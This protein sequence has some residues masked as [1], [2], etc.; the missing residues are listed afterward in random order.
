MIL[1]VLYFQVYLLAT[2][3]CASA[4]GN[5]SYPAAHGGPVVF[6]GSSSAT[7]SDTASYAQRVSA[8]PSA[9]SYGSGTDD[10]YGV[11]YGYAGLYPAEYGH[12][13]DCSYGYRPY[14]YRTY[15]DYQGYHSVPYA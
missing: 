3:A 10:V 11:Q 9:Y 8:R 2:V 14:V 15:Y 4:F 12:G 7:P 5:S 1:F 13:Y 6:H